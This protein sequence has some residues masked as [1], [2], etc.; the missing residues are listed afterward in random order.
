M[1]YILK[2]ES[3]P[4]TTC[5]PGRTLY[6]L[7]PSFP[8]KQR[9]VTALESIVAGGRVSREKAEADAVSIKVSFNH[10]IFWEGAEFWKIFFRYLTYWGLTEGKLLLLPYGLS[11]RSQFTVRLMLCITI[12]F[13]RLEECSKTVQKYLCNS[14]RGRKRV[15]TWFKSSLVRYHIK[16]AN[17]KRSKT[18]L[19]PI[20]REPEV[21]C[22]LLG[23][24][25]CE[26]VLF[27]LFSS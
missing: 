26:C 23:G 27:S 8:D 11:T 1:P 19:P 6:L 9:W 15:R 2:L 7:A 10:K 22:F 3:H 5:W 12:P 4:H 24:G 16:W 14:S 13:F 25:L 21:L 18:S 17:L 20:L